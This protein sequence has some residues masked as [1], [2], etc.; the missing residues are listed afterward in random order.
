[1]STKT[2]LYSLLETVM[3]PEIPTVSIVDLGI[4][5]DVEIQ[6]SGVKVVITPTYSGC[7]AMH[8][9]EEEIR[10]LLLS[11]G[12]LVTIEMKYS[13]AWSTDWMTEKGKAAM[14]KSGIAPPCHSAD[15]NL[16]KFPWEKTREGAVP[17]PR[18][19]SN[20]TEKRSEFGSTA[21]KALYYC[22]QCREPFDYFKV[23]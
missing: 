6:G 7:P 4:V 9:I 5:R 3:D 18:C 20:N 2:V 13:P 8:M 11:E 1:M 17:C 16:V 10:A 12:Y 14:K 22:N 19:E 15:T 23:F 21:C